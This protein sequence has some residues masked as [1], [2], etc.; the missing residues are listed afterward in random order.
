VDLNHK[1]IVLTGAASGIGRAL[2]E[3][4]ATYPLEIVAAD[5]NETRLR[6]V[7]AALNNPRAKVIPVAGDTSSQAGND[8]LFAVAQREMNGVDVFIANAGYAHYEH[9]TQPDWERLERLFRVNVFAPIYALQRMTAL[10][11][12]REF[13]VVWVASA[14]AQI[15]FPKYAAYSASKSAL[16]RFADAHRHSMPDPTAL[17]L[18]YPIATR[19]RFFDASSDATP[20]PTP[21]QSPEEVARAIL[22]GIARDAL[23]VY[24][25]RVFRVMLWLTLW[26]P[27]LRRFIQLREIR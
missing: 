4:L 6:E 20:V 18:V 22:N 25:S 7:C 17:M 19:T 3:E 11:L 16:H 27:G 8:A 10:N 13:K 24:P 23:E 12:G 9:A 15:G 14:M 5:L 21:N 2:L 1:R 26:L